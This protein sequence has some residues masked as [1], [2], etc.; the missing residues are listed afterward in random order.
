LEVY[1]Y[2]RGEVVVRMTK[3]EYTE[4]RNFARKHGSRVHLEDHKPNR[5]FVRMSPALLEAFKTDSANISE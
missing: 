3:S 5:Y 1:K 2:K 4:I